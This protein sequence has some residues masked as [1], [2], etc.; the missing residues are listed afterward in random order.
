MFNVHSCWYLER[1]RDDFPD[2]EGPQTKRKKIVGREHMSI[3]HP[4]LRYSYDQHV[5]PKSWLRVY[6]DFSKPDCAVMAKLGHGLQTCRS[7]ENEY[8]LHVTI[9]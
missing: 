2:F 5:V 7:D 9:R 1:Y 8:A 6:S 3:E 4:Y